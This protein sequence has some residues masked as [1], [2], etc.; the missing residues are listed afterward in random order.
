MSFPQHFHFSKNKITMCILELNLIFPF[1]ENSSGII[2]VQLCILANHKLVFQATTPESDWWC[3]P[4]IK[5]KDSVF[6][7]NIFKLQ[8]NF[9]NC[10]G[11][12][13]SDIHFSFFVVA[14]CKER[15]YCKTWNVTR[16][17]NQMNDWFQ[18]KSSVNRAEMCIK[19]FWRHFHQNAGSL[20]TFQLQYHPPSNLYSA[21]LWVI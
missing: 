17:N 10:L 9:N 15:P 19:E 18:K 4:Q 20:N 1:H 2:H 7:Q 11:F 21:K 5:N 3:H 13:D 6:Y 14:K 12:L 16:D 8:R